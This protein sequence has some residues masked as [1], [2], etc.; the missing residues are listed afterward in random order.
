VLLLWMQAEQRGVVLSRVAGYRTWQGM[1]RQVV[2]GA[3]SFAMRAPSA[4]RSR[5]SRPTSEPGWG[6]GP[7]STATGRPAWV[8]RG[9]AYL[10]SLRAETR[11]PSPAHPAPLP[12]PPW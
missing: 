10:R 2:K 1:G 6:S 12:H 9:S 4:A 5:W 8:V 3:R 11:R 7:R